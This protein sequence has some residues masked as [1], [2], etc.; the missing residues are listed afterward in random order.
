MLAWSFE[1]T[2]SNAH[3]LCFRDIKCCRV[4]QHVFNNRD[5][6]QTTAKCIFELNGMPQ[7]LLQYNSVFVV[8]TKQQNLPGGALGVEQNVLHRLHQQ[9]FCPTLS[10][11]LVF[12]KKSTVKFQLLLCSNS[13]QRESA[14]FFDEQFCVKELGEYAV[15][16]F[17]CDFWGDDIPSMQ[18]ER[19]PVAQD[20]LTGGDGLQECR[21]C[22]SNARSCV[23]VP[24]GHCCACQVC[25]DKMHKCPICKQS[26]AL[27][28]RIYLS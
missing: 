8:A 5:Q 18:H 1:L 7:H 20:E 2:L 4:L 16:I 9:L 10:Q 14:I 17:Q 12:E 21:I 25:A 22:M 28:Q 11:T 27:K 26:I 19:V 13:D 23:F 15:Y 24:C 6:E 3:C